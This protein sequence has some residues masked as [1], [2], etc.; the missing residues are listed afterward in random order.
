MEMPVD[1][2][3]KPSREPNSRI[4]LIGDQPF[5]HTT[6]LGGEESTLSCQTFPSM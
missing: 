1:S 6:V 5:E 4:G 2:L 3:L